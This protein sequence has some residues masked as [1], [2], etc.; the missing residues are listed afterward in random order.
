MLYNQTF[1]ILCGNKIDHVFALFEDLP[2][3]YW[4][5]YLYG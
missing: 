2:T 3:D 5:T 1:W 4:K